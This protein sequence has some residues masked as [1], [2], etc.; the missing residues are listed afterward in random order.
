MVLTD[1][2]SETDLSW[3]SRHTVDG[4]THAL[5]L[6]PIACAIAFFAFLVSCGAGMPS[7]LLGAL[8][9]AIAW[10]LTLVVMIIDFV[11]FGAVKY[12]VNNDGSGSHAY[13]SAGM[14]CALAAMILLFLG[15]SIDLFTCFSGRKQEERRY[16]NT[17][18]LAH[19][20]E[21]EVNP[22]YGRKKRFGVF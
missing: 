8:I 21:G 4:L 6:H 7:S 22:T 17:Q 5:V 2:A 18:S 1:H 13:Y 11:I 9:A 20:T 15:M 19:N 16:S 12:H 10:I 14:W 3:A